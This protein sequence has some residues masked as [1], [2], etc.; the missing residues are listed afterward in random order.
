[1]KRRHWK[2]QRVPDLWTDITRPLSRTVRRQ[3]E[4][5]GWTPANIAEVVAARDRAAAE[6]A[7]NRGTP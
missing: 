4:R 5:L 7:S 2:P 6:I 3:L 1:M